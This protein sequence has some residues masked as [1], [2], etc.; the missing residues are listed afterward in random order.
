MTAAAIVAIVAA[1]V[2]IAAL[3]ASYLILVGVR[4]QEQLLDRELEQGREQFDAIVAKEIEERSRQLELTLAR[5]RAESLSLL[6]E[7]ERRIAAERRLDV[8]ERER[9]GSEQLAAQLVL[10]RRPWN[11]AC[12]AG[13]PT[14]RSCRKD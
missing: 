4:N 7:E 10:H 6:A 8:V 2:A 11:S 1:V 14:S 9:S 13:P 12:P 3:V 5:E